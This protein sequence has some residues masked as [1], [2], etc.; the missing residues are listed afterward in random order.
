MFA[1]PDAD[2]LVELAAGLNL[3][4]SHAEAE[5][6]LPFVRDA[7]HELD[8]FVQSRAE[9][10]AP[11][12]LFPERGRG[13]RPSLTEDRWQ[14]WLWK[15]AIGGEDR[16]LLAGK[17]VSFKDHISVAGIPQ[18]FTSQALEGFVPD[19]DATVVSRVLAA[20]GKVTGKHMMNGSWVT[21]AGR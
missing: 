11:P 8:T 21:T 20:G 1:N 18:V 13:Y 9:E 19:V 5:L 2:Q 7:M 17:T 10:A 4:L 3:R 15:C 14:A 12:L 16:G 6:Y